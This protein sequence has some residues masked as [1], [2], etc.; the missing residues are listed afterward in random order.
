MTD[1]PITQPDVR[2]V[3]IKQD[4]GTGDAGRDWRELQAEFASEENAFAADLELLMG[5]LRRERRRLG[6]TQKA[7]A[8]RMN[9]SQSR[10][11][12]IETGDLEKTEVRTLA[13]Y[14]SALGIR[15]R[16]ITD[17]GK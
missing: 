14:F 12:A 8:E 5:R 17:F 15:L 7:V 6:L 4:G 9:V 10:V 3:A 1:K 11:S 13:R 16:L 2:I